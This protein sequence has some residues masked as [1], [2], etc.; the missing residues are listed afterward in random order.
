MA[1]HKLLGFTYMP[2]IYVGGRAQANVALGGKATQSST[3][4]SADA[5][6]AIDGS[7]NWNGKMGSC[8]ETKPSRNPWWTVNLK[9]VYTVSTVRITN[10]MDCC[11]NELLGAELRIGNSVRSNA[12]DNKLCGKVT[13]VTESYT[14][15]C[16]GF[17]GQYVNIVIPGHNKVLTLCEVEVFG[18]LHSR[19]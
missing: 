15:I 9:R 18:K 1:L 16:R 17:T 14:F 5:H 4:F 8:T 19:K 13:T 3:Q 10:R 7:N 11:S 12:N 6:R 2:A